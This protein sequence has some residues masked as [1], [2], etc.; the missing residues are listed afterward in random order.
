MIYW[1]A[2]A[3]HQHSKKEQKID[4]IVFLIPNPHPP[5]DMSTHLASTLNNQLKALTSHCL[6]ILVDMHEVYAW[7]TLLLAVK[8]NSRAP[9]TALTTYFHS[10]LNCVHYGYYGLLKGASK[11]EEYL[12]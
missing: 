10:Q 5:H 7:V 9:G 3:I 4:S 6:V 8:A 11:A 2:T 1:E 12:S